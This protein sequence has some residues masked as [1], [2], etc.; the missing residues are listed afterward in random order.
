MEFK[1]GDIV[2]H[3]NKDFGV[4]CVKDT[5]GVNKVLVEFG[6]IDKANYRRE[7]FPMDEIVLYTKK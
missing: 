4:G 1:L 5:N 3:K 2:F 7:W 6:T